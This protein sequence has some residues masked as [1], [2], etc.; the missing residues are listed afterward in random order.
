MSQPRPELL[1]NSS[2]GTPFLI[3][4]RCRHC[5][6]VAFP[7]DPYGC[8]ACG[9]LIDQ[10]DCVELRAAGVV[11]AVATVHRHHRE[12]PPTPFT[13]AAIVL[14][15]GPLLKAV[16]T[17]QSAGAQVGDR[18]YGIAEPPDSSPPLRFTRE[19]GGTGVDR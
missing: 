3:G 5:S 18:V 7:P 8:E 12:V 13:V 9:A 19:H 15:D 16:L 2:D 17:D 11:Q 1:G 10:L 14:D 4:Q 6:R